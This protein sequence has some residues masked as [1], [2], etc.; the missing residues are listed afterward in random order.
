[1]TSTLTITPNSL[2]LQNIKLNNSSISTSKTYRYDE[3]SDDAGS[4]MSKQS[5][6]NQDNVPS[7]STL[8]DFA[9]VALTDFNIHQRMQE[10]SGF[11]VFK[12]QI[13][14][15]S[16][17]F[18]NYDDE[19]P[20]Y[21]SLKCLKSKSKSRDVMEQEANLLKQEAKMISR[22][23]HPNIAKAIG[24]SSHSP[25]GYFLAFDLIEE[26]LEERIHAWKTGQVPKL[27]NRQYSPDAKKGGK[28]KPPLLEERL[29]HC[30]LGVARAMMYLHARH[31][32]NPLRPNCIG[33]DRT[34]CI[35]IFDFST[36]EDHSVQHMRYMSPEYILSNEASFESD[37]YSL[38]III[39]QV[40]TLKL[41]FTFLSKFEKK[42][43]SVQRNKAIAK[44]LVSKRPGT[45]G[46]PDKELRGLIRDCLETN[47]DAR[48]SATRLLFRLAECLPKQESNEQRLGR[49][50]A[51]L[52]SHEAKMS[53]KNSMDEDDMVS[54]A[55]GYDSRITR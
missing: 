24:L 54:T 21:F 48:P 23:R 15:N 47:P 22:L 2:A 37:V 7:L 50:E 3:Y 41:P 28:I 31:I 6:Y 9:P 44:K 55:S 42:P 32:V 18:D 35:K 40:A 29:Y 12:V 49:I 53:R 43:H 14:N 27:K 26:S 38:G 8:A 16:K 10:G 45:S 13:N 11:Q 30:I 1:M 4:N 46:I 25:Y 39:W 19:T 20:K 36:Y 33:F 51:L 5:S 34:G 17:F 52:R